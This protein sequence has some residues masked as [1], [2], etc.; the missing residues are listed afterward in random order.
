[1]VYENDIIEMLDTGKQYRAVSLNYR[2]GNGWLF[3]LFGKNPLPVF[4]HTV[5]LEDLIKEPKKAVVLEAIGNS[6][7]IK[8]SAAAI[9]ERDYA[10]E[11]ITP[12]ISTDDI[13]IPSERNRI[14]NDRAAQLSCSPRTLLRLLRLFWAGGQTRHALTPNYQSRGSTKGTTSNRGRPAKY[15]DRKIYQVKQEDLKVFKRC[16]DEKYLK[17][18]TATIAGTYE[19]MLLEHYSTVDSEGQLQPRAPGE[20]P[21][22]EQF[23]RYYKGNYSLETVIRH[24]E[25]NAEFELNHAPKL[26]D[27]ELSVYTV[28]DNFEIDATVGD[29][30]LVSSVDRSVI[31]GKPTIYLAI[32]SKSWLIVGFYVG[33]EQPSWPPALEAIVSIAEDKQA[34]CERYGVPYRSEDWPAHGVLPKEFTADRGGEWVSKASS[35]ISDGLECT[36]R[37][38]PARAAK[39]KPHVECGI[40]LIQKPMAEHLPGYEPPQEARKRQGKHYEKDACLN[41]AEFIETVLRAV[42]RFNNSARDDYPMTPTQTLMGLI[43][44]PCN[45]WNHEIRSRAGSLSRYSAQF[46][47]EA[48]LPHGKATVT[49]EGI[50]FGECYYS[51]DE[52]IQR[53][54][55]VRAGR[56]A[57]KVEIS[58]DRRLVDTILIHDDINPGGVFVAT[59]LESSAHFKGM[60]LREVEAV[61][62]ERERIRQEGR[63][64]ART[65]RFVFHSAVDEM[66]KTAK[67]EARRQSKGKSRS[68]RKADIRESRSEELARERQETAALTP[69]VAPQQSAEIL[70]F[71][72]PTSNTDSINCPKAAR[73]AKLLEMLNGN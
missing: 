52:A 68:A 1:M 61:A 5:E 24:R 38:L 28:G 72:P 62:F 16:I 42:I 45:L 57:F 64:L 67:E 44:T 60:S 11:S 32:D 3:P 51:C 37:N 4:I 21:T 10:F 34:L 69:H 47:R 7:P 8:A 27:A 65:P 50:R 2:T 20:F 71:Q 33:F 58:Y 9:R 53:N 46:L 55:F 40:K 6:V 63:H 59:L 35:K 43:P 26:G 18:L 19:N 56:G 49:R 17:G 14:I 48:L 25:G 12:L 23:R 73:N 22:I 70:P 29:V 31:V 13:F 66:T 30:Y 36:L 39:R 15:M 41:L 54:W